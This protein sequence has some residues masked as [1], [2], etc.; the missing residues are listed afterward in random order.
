MG[1]VKQ[2]TISTHALGQSLSI[3]YTKTG[4]LHF[5]LLKRCH[6]GEFFQRILYGALM[7]GRFRKLLG[8][9]LKGAGLERSLVGACV[10]P[11]PS[12]LCASASV[13]AFVSS[14]PLTAGGQSGTR[15]VVGG[16]LMSFPEALGQGGSRPTHPSSYP[17][18]GLRICGS[19]NK[20]VL[21]LIRQFMSFSLLDRAVPVL[22]RRCLLC[23]ASNLEEVCSRVVGPNILTTMCLLK[24]HEGAT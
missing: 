19:R 20:N 9:G 18:L 23:L 13:R 2:A 14:Q 24:V 8:L 4:C 21:V 15:T 10:Y 7:L 1:L 12:G 17:N 22:L 11:L 5:R 16:W 3:S 6:V